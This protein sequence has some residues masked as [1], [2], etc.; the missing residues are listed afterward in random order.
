MMDKAVTFAPYDAE[1]VFLSARQLGCQRGGRVLFQ[2]LDFE[3]KAGEVVALHGMNGSGKTS[4]LRMIAGLLAIPDGALSAPPPLSMHY[5]AHQSGLSSRLTVSEIL[6]FWQNW[7]G[8][9]A[10]LALDVE[11]ALAHLGLGAQADHMSGELSAGQK[12]RLALA[13]LLVAPRP[14]WLLDEPTTALDATG[15]KTLQNLIESH[16]AANG[17]VMM[18]THDQP[19]YVSQKIQLPETGGQLHGV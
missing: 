18:A 9:G 8:M 6:R 19:V 3:L 1:K 7:L 16:L 2:G 13:R 11:A 14:I 4:L 15:Q 17:L 5:I 10:A 12:R